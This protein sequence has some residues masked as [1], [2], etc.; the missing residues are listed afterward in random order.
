MLTNAY[1]DALFPEHYGNKVEITMK[2]GR[3]FKGQY[4]DYAGS[5]AKPF[6]YEQIV[7]KFEGL[8]EK[9]YEP[10]AAARLEENMGKLPQ[11]ADVNQLFAGLR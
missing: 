1:F 7:G 4:V 9:V 2:D 6:G 8:V 10:S 3:I 11:M 5:A